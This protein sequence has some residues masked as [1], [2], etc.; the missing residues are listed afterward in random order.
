MKLRGAGGVVAGVLQVLQQDLGGALGPVEETAAR[1]AGTTSIA[2]TRPTTPAPTSTAD[3]R[4]R[5]CPG[6]AVT[7]TA[8]GRLNEVSRTPDLP[9]VWNLGKG[10]GRFGV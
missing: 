9:S 7:S 10:G 8:S 4:G 3:A 6:T 1:R 2:A 5:P